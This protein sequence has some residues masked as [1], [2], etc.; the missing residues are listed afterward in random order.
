LA[1]TAQ[2]QTRAWLDR[3]RIAL[4]ETATLNVETGQP[5]V[6]APDYSPLLGDFALSGNSS[7]QQYESIN[8]TSHSRTLYAVALQ[9]KRD[10]VIG[11]PALRIGSQRTQPL[12][13]TVTPSSA[14]PAHAG[15]AVFIEAETDAQEP[16]VQQAVGYTVRL[17]YAAPL[18]SGQLDQDPPEGASLQRVG[19]DAQFTRDMAGHRYTV[20]ERHY[21]LLPERSG[22]LTIPGAR[23][24]GRGAGGFF[25]D[26]FGDGQRELRASGAPRFVRVRAIPANAPQPW[27]PLRA[28]NLR[29]L[30]T[31]QA[32]RAGEAITVT[33]EAS[34]DGANAAQMPELQLQA[35]D[36]QAGAAQIFPDPL[37]ADET[38]RDGR[39]QVRIARKFSIVPSQAG[40]LRISGPRLQWWDVRAGI[41]RTASLPD[42]TVQVAPGVNGLGGAPTAAATANVPNASRDWIR[43]P[44]V[45][46]AVQP[47]A[48][49]AAVFALLWLGT[50]M[51][52]LHRRPQVAAAND[53]ATPAPR[54]APHGTHADLRRALDNGDLGDVS[55]V[56][57]A[58][59]TPAVGDPDALR[60]LLAD[61]D[62][63]A[64]IESL[65]R[66]RWAGGDGVAA[67]AALRVAFKQGPRWRVVEPVAEEPLPPLY[68]R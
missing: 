20:V 23:F 25:D 6:D 37:Q 33:I 36:T 49:A 31:P 18:I 44:G 24:Q 1:A 54:V 46:G 47:W 65:L 3:D 16:Y 38:F 55:D 22:T 51:W 29:Y 14:V 9:P 26:L 8:G 40:S 58:M 10:G 48:L 27:L 59:A 12:T 13:L 52:G 45:Q 68:P 41:A 34:A 56:L 28:L 66:A 4:G 57:C 39:P 5:G 11:I 32:A 43:V 63:V 67:R 61:P 50:F 42:I 30:A 19:D 62:Q 15:D 60:A 7:S 53:D 21:L 35:G 2:S 17:Y 64:A